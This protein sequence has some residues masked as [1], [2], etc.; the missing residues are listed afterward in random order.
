MSK[1]A[2]YLAFTTLAILSLILAVVAHLK[3]ASVEENKEFF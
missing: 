1:T 3:K 2:N